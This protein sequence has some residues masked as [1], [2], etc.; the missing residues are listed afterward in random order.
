[1]LTYK[2]TLYGPLGQTHTLKL[3][4]AEELPITEYVEDLNED[5]VFVEKTNTTEET[6]CGADKYFHHLEECLIYIKNYKFAEINPVS[7]TIFTI[8]SIE[9]CNLYIEDNKLR[10]SQYWPSYIEYNQTLIKECVEEEL[11]AYITPQVLKWWLQ[12]VHNDET[13]MWEIILHRILKK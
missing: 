12:V 3:Y 13:D 10:F 4:L 11:K 5:P 7:Q 2:I 8:R 1:M 6:Y 9:G